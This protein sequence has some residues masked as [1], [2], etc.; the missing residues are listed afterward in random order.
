LDCFCFASIAI[1]IFMSDG[2]CKWI[3]FM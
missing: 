1:N 2:K 3:W